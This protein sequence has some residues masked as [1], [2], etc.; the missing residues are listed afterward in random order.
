MSQRLVDLLAAIR[1]EQ[2]PEVR[3]RAAVLLLH[4]LTCM[5]TTAQETLDEAL[6]QLRRRGT[7]EQ[8]IGTL[9]RLPAG[10]SLH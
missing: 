6:A 4:D 3:A 2:D 9:L 7:D 5:R 1:G 8:Y 10:A